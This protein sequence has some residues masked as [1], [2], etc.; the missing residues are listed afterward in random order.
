VAEY[1]IITAWIPLS[2]ERLPDYRNYPNILSGI[3]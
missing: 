1:R 2:A 3:N